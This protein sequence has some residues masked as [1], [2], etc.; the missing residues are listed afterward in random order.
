MS[1]EQIELVQKSWSQ[2][3]PLSDQAARL[4]YLRLF[5]QEPELRPLYKVSMAEQGEKLG[6]TVGVAVACL[7]KLVSHFSI[8]EDLG[9]GPHEETA[10][11]YA[12]TVLDSWDW[13]LEQTLGSTYTPEAREAWQALFP[14]Q[15]GTMLLDAALAPEA[16][17]LQPAGA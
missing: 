12:E 9:E 1:P 5:E 8:S 6:K 2:A 10:E 4:F 16:R 15:A 13:A 11:P 7:T 14:T 3:E 17:E